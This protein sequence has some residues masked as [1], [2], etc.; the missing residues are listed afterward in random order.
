M[1]VARQSPMTVFMLAVFSTMV[2]IA[3]TYPEDARFMPLSSASRGSA[4]RAADRARFAGEPKKRTG[5]RP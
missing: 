1:K 2:G 4:L 3:A 5:R